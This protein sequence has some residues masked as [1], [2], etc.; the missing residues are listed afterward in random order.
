MKRID[1]CWLGDGM[2]DIG[3]VMDHGYR[4]NANVMGSM[5][6]RCLPAV[7]SVQP[8]TLHTRP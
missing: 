3:S 1:R 4:M 8:P 6:V 7:L 2:G 5:D